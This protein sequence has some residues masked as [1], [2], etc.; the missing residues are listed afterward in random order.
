MTPGE[1]AVFVIGML[2]LAA[3]IAFSVYIQRND[4]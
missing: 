3:A 2:V 1:V 4:P